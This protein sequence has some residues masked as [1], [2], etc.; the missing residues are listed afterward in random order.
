MDSY[1]S[2]PIKPQELFEA[3]ESVFTDLSEVETTSGE[4]R[5]AHD[6]I[7]M[8]EVLERAGGDVE[9]VMEVAGLFLD[10]CPMLLS[11]MQEAIARQ[12]S[13]ALERA[14][15]TL[16]G[17]AANLVAKSVSEAAS[18]LEMIGRDGEITRAQEAYKVLEEEVQRLSPVLATLGKAE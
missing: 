11:E 5:P 1:V 13:K 6:P 12:D 10:N 8:G 2:K 17:S 18:R 9:L 3:I 16:K 14:A 7:N 4:T 15:H